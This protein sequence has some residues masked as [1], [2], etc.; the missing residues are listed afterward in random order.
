MA[1]VT[2]NSYSHALRLLNKTVQREI[3]NERGAIIKTMETELLSISDE[4]LATLKSIFQASPTCAEAMIKADT[5]GAT[6]SSQHINEMKLMDIK[7][8]SSVLKY[9]LIELEVFDF[10]KRFYLEQES[11]VNRILS[12]SGLITFLMK[13]ECLL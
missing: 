13:G 7:E 12:F 9:V 11:A 5:L 1:V 10:V 2:T 8:L 6:Q 3:K 4:T